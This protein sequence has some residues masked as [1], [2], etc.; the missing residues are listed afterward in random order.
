MKTGEKIRGLRLLRGF[1]QENMAE[2]LKISRNA[3]SEFERNITD[4]SESRLIQIAEVLKI[5]IKDIYNFEE[6]KLFFFNNSIEKNIL[7]I[8]ELNLKNKDLEH[9]IE[10]LEHQLEIQ[11]LKTENVILEKEKAEIELKYWKEKFEID[12]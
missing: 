9:K 10:L 5:R 8:R 1:S 6:N 2:S 7:L 11:Q 4:I 12:K 3:Y